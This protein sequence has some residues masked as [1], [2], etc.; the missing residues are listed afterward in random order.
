[1]SKR[2][3]DPLKKE[4]GRAF[5]LTAKTAEYVSF[6]FPKKESEVRADLFPPFRADT[7]AHTFADWAGGQNK[8]PVLQEHD[9]KEL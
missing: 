7:A 5:R 8:N 3:V 6:L 1:M 4:V 2:H 9:I